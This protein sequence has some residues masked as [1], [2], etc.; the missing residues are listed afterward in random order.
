M[1]GYLPAHYQYQTHR[2]HVRGVGM[3]EIL[4]TLFILSIG[5]LGVVYLQFVGSFTNSESLNRSQSVLVAQ[6]MSERL[7]ASATFS[8][9]GDGLVV[10]NAYFNADL[11][12]FKTLSCTGGGQ[13][14]DCFCKTR[15]ATIP[16]CNDNVCSTAEL[17]Q[18]DAYELSCAAVISN[19]DVSISLT[20]EDNVVSDAQSCSVGSKHIVTLKWPVENWQNIDRTLNAK[21]NVDETSPHDC[22]S[23]DITL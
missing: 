17:A 2:I 23:L 13:P 16:N 11:Y 5:L 21:C 22:V 8:V 20:C 1:L 6:Q 4:V 14:Y 15:P 10:D 12:N 9:S 3:I 7:R 18:F 19:P